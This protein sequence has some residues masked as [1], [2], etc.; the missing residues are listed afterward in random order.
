MPC[1]IEMNYDLFFYKLLWEH[2]D[3]AG[4]HLH[5]IHFKVFLCESDVTLKV[6]WIHLH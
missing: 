1:I 4:L 6:K 5:S 2:V 3:N